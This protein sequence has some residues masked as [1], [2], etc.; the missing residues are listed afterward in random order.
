MKPNTALVALIVA[1]S[2]SARAMPGYQSPA[3]AVPNLTGTVLEVLDAGPYTYLKLKTTEGEV[4]SAV[5]KAPVKKGETVT[6]APDTVMENFESKALNR[7]FDRVV[8]A[9]I[10]TAPATGANPHART[11]APSAKVAKV[12]KAEGAD[13]RTV[14]QVVSGRA[15]LK[16]KTV[17]IRGQVVKVTS[18]VLD[19]N[20]IHLQDGS[21]SSAQGT[22]DIVVTSRE[23]IAV[24]EIVVVRG[25]VRT[26]VAI[27]PG[28][29]YQVLVE[30]AKLKKS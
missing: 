1:T 14:E 2:F 8:F 21:G 19:K 16:G 12:P 6:L 23:A 13:A 20:W 5:Q 26:D 7:K 24:G 30:D 3:G 17:A 28:Y 29:A 11:I 22:H 15:S 9:S 10:A 25:T 27:G 4:W 18:G